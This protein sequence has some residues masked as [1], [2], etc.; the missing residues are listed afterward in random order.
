M[1]KKAGLN[2]YVDAAIASRLRETA[3]HYDGRLG[4]CIGA[5]ILMFLEATPSAQAAAM[6]RLYAASLTGSVESL[7]AEIQAEQARRTLEKN[8][9]HKSD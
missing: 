5:G 8:A 3:A 4:E 9:K 1:A 7:I 6:Q 2:V